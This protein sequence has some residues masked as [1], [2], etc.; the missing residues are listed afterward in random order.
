MTRT[1]ARSPVVTIIL[2]LAMVLGVA[3]GT[4]TPALSADSPDSIARAIETAAGPSGA[5]GIPAE[6]L[7]TP[8]DVTGTAPMAHGDLALWV[9][10]QPGV[11]YA[12]RNVAGGGQQTLVFISS[13]EAPTDYEF[14]LPQGF[15]AKAG[16]DGGVAVFNDSVYVGTIPAPWATDANGARVPTSYKVSSDGMGI[17]QSVNHLGAAYPVVAD[18][19]WV[20]WWGGVDIYLSRSETA[21]A[22]TGGLG[23]IFALFTGPYVAMIGA[24][25]LQQAI[26]NAWRQN[27]CIVLHDS[28]VRPSY[29][30]VYNC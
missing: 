21:W 19:R 25:V 24:G 22:V 9:D 3:V 29:T 16:V 1:K 17:I 4:R 12:A 20:W 7:L 11:S 10:V 23:A 30:S 6:T 13:A 26:Q 18:P 15:T 5:S 27:K 14:N 8:E 28:W 2:A